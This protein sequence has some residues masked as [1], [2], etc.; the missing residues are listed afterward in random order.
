MAGKDLR[1]FEFKLPELAADTTLSFTLYDTDGIHNRLPFV[2][3]LSA[4]PDDPPQLSLQLRGIGSAITPQ[5]SLPLAGEIVDDYGIDSAAFHVTIDEQKTVRP[6]F[7]TQPGGRSE[8]AVDEAYDVRDL[9]LKPGEKILFGAEARDAYHLVEGDQPHTAT[10][11]RFQLDVVTP[12]TLAR[13]SNPRAQP[14]AAF[15]NDHCR[16]DGNPRLAGHDPRISCRRRS[17]CRH[18][19]DE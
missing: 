17:S 13:C 2:V 7:A 16:G 8:F 11:E 15:R 6:A 1:T 4:V 14:P 10:G 12:E 5:A 19:L 18:R 3:S 9:E